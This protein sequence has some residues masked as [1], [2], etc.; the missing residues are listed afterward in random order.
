MR[1]VSKHKDYY[2]GCASYGQS[3]GLM[4]IR[5]QK[6][7]PHE[8]R[9]E[10]FSD[11]S[12]L[13]TVVIGFC[14]KTYGCIRVR[15]SYA[16]SEQDFVG[17]YSVEDLDKLVDKFFDDSRKKDYHKNISRWVLDMHDRHGIYNLDG[18]RPGYERFFQK[19]PNI[20][21]LH[22]YFEKYKTAIFADNF[23]TKCLTINPVLKYYSFAKVFDPYQAF[24]E[25]QMFVG[26]GIFNEDKPI[27]PMADEDWADIKGFDKYSFRSQERP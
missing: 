10:H 2:D 4:Y 3:D 1:I 18:S 26:S 5:E 12:R 6:E 9:R 16:G 17:A 7:I 8:N 25:L 13:Q 14:G 19:A 15:E 24:Q 21:S 20:P 22:T 23:S 11:L 27:P